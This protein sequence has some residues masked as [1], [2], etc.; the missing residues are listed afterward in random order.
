MQPGCDQ[1]PDPDTS[2]VCNFLADNYELPGF[3]TLEGRGGNTYREEWCSKLGSPGEWGVFSSHDSCGY[4]DCQPYKKMDSP[5]NGCVPI[6]GRGVLCQRQAFNGN[7]PQCCFNDYVC[8]GGNNCWSDPGTNKNTCDPTTRDITTPQCQEFT[9]FYC[10]GQDLQPGDSS[11]IFRWMN[12]D[13]TPVPQSCLYSLQRNLFSLTSTPCF[14]GP[15]IPPTG[16]NPVDPTLFPFNFNGY[17]SGQSMMQGVFDRYASNGFVIGSLPGTPGFNPFQD[18]LFQNVC[19][20]YTSL[21]TAGLERTCAVYSTQGLVQNPAAVEW[22]GC[23]LPPGEYGTYSNRYQINRECTP[24]CNRQDV[25][26]VVDV[27]GKGVTCNQNV[28]LIDNVTIQLTNS[29]VNGPVEIGQLC[30]GCTGS[31][32]CTCII[33]DN[34]FDAANSQIGGGVNLQQSCGG[35][36]TCTRSNQNTSGIPSVVNVDCN[37]PVSFDPFAQYNARVEEAQKTA[38]EERDVRVIVILVLALLFLFFLYLVINR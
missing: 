30:G 16:C 27:N 32:S 17:L 38:D 24:M 33:E 19:C 4:S 35:G 36:N 8:T 2:N 26:P 25:I 11:W 28:C 15:P 22:C 23:Y 7:D 29:L 13:G 21:C 5:C 1:P 10:T 20:P 37:S 14:T 31:T 18:F 6:A 34:T 9:Q 12:P 3:C